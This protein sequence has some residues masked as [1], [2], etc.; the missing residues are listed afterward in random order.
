MFR[1]PYDTREVLRHLD[2]LGAQSLP[3]VGATGLVVGLILAIQSR[4]VLA[5]FGAESYVPAMVSISVVRELGP[6]LTALM[7]AG[8]VGSGI[9]AEL[10]SM[11]VTEQI[12]ALEVSGTDSFRFLVLTRVLA[13]TL[14]LP[15][16]AGIVNV[17]AILGAYLSTAMEM[18]MSWTLYF[19][20]AVYSLWLRDVLPAI[21]KT[22][23]FG[24]IIGVIGCHE[25]YT[26]SGGT[27]GVGR[28]STKA[29]VTASLLLL[30]ADMVL[31]RLIVLLWN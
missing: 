26:A 29:V 31:G 2:E 7:V 4:P 19:H 3:V 15:L 18:D 20:R 5:R 17:L 22:V 23:I 28:A 24:F 8:R 30:F 11:R 10:G 12:D 16:L 14:L 25:G 27:A 6:I 1:P 13:C 21:G 9:S